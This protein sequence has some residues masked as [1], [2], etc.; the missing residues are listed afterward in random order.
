VKFVV[1][2]VISLIAA[3]ISSSASAQESECRVVRARGASFLEKCGKQLNSFSLSLS[4]NKLDL[5]LKEVESDL[6]GRFTFTCPFEPLCANEPIIGG[7][8]IAAESWQNSSRDERAIYQ[9]LQRVPLM[10]ISWS[11]PGGPTPEMPAATCPLFDVSV[12]G[13]AGRAVCFDDPTAKAASV[14]VVAADDR[15]GFLLGFYQRDKSAN[16]LRDK[17]LELMPRFKIERAIGDV[18]LLKW[19]K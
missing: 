19:V 14:I 3:A 16:A 7:F 18:G 2:V 1:A 10:A 9:A 17:V 15:V 6:H 13:M 4:E 8:F 12:D 11:R 5:I